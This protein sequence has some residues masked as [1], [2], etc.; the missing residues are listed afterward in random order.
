MVIVESY[1]KTMHLALT[2]T[3]HTVIYISTA[4]FVNNLVIKYQ[5]RYYHLVIL[6]SATCCM[7]TNTQLHKEDEDRYVIAGHEDDEEFQQAF[8]K[9]MLHSLCDP[10]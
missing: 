9:R 7:L 1:N 4:L 2:T 10:G 6:F 8:W 3:V 5:T